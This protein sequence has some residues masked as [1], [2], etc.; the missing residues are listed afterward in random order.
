MW[1]PQFA[2]S[3]G[4][5]RIIAPQL[6][7]F[8]RG[9]SEKPAQSMDDYAG[10][11][12]DLLDA[13]HLEEAVIGGLSLGGYVTFAL[14][15]RAPQYFQGMVLADTRSEAD[16]PEGVEGRK[17]M[18]ALVREQGPPAVAETMIPK[19]LAE[20]TRQNQ[21]DVVE[22]MRSLMLS[23]STDV[24]AGAVTAMMGRQDSTPLLESI[25]CPTLVL[26]GEHD[27]L[28]PPALSREMHRRI[29]GSELV[30]IPDAGHL[31]NVEQPQTFNR[32]LGDFLRRR[33]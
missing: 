15:R 8:D 31:S 19:L 14:F 16:S 26:V 9:S 13:L 23:N 20:E 6:R 22:R 25:R 28:T 2:L 24:I 1:E 3:E 30:T 10:D 18:I 17:K 29:E 12:I 27:Q 11:V 5:W 21:A 32:A 7:G 33:F 4:G